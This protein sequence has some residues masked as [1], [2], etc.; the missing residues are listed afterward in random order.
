MSVSARPSEAA[1]P[2]PRRRWWR[3]VLG[4]V[5]LL[6]LLPV[7]AVGGALLWANSEGGRA[8]LARL[9]AG[10]VPGLAIEG[11]EGPLPGRLAFE[12][13]AMSDDQ[14]IWLEIEG[15]RLDWDPLALLR[16]V[17]H[18][19]ALTA[20]RIVLHRLPPGEEPPPP[21]EPGPLIPRLPDLPV[22]LQLDRLEVVRLEL[23]EPVLGAPAVLR[24]EGRAG[25][26]AGGLTAAL[27]A[28]AEGG[29]TAL[30]L[31]AALRPETGRLSAR[32]TL[33]GEA[34]GPVARLI[35]LPDRPTSLDLT[36][37]GPAEA[38]ALTLQASAGPGLGAEL[39]GTLRAPD[40][41]RIGAEIAGTVDASGLL[42]DPVAPFAGPLNLRL[43]AG[44]M[45]DGAVDLRALRIAGR[46]GTIEASGRLDSAAA[47]S[48]LRLRAAL[49]ASTTFAALLPGDTAG[50]EAVRLEAQVTG[51][52]NA[53]RVTAELTAEGFRSG[54]APLAAL[55]G[56]TPRVTLRAAAPDRIELLTVTGQSLQAELRGRVG[57][58]LDVSYAANVAAVE[59]AAPGLS[60][61]LRLAGTATGPATNPNLTL[62]AQSNRLQVAERVLEALSLTARIASPAT[63]PALEARATGRFQNLPLS[64]DLR[65]GPEADGWLRLQAAEASFGPARLSASGR[66]QPEQKLVDGSARL[67]VPQ[68]APFSAV[69]GQPLAGSVRLEATAT[70][71]EGQQH[72]AARLDVPNLRAAGV[73]ARGF[74]ASAQGTLAALDLALAGRV[75]EVDAELRGRLTE[76]EGGIRRLD[77]AT[78]RAAGFGETV[79]LAAPARLALHPDGGVEIGALAITL[80][81][82]GTLR[83]EG[84]WGPERAD[85]RAQLTPL[86]I[87]AF[88]A[89]VPEIGPSGTV[90]A[91]ARITG[92]TAAPEVTATLRGTALRAR[93]PWA[94]G[95]PAGE[96]RLDLRRNGEGAVEANGEARLGTAMR[97]NATARLPRGPG[98]ELPV[99]ASLDGNLE[100]APLA[101][102]M[103]AAGADRV[104]GRLAL[105]LRMS[106]TQGAPVLG[107]EARLS[108]GSYRN[109]LMGV[110][111]TDLAGTVR[112]DGPLLRVDIAGRTPGD[113]RLNL[114]GTIEPMTTNIPVDLALTATQAQPV[115][116]D[117]LRT[118]LD[119]ELR[120][121][122]LLGTGATVAG[123]V[124]IRRAEIRV[125]EKLPTTVRSLGPVTERGAPPG[126]A[127]RRAPPRR[128]PAQGGGSVPI[129]LA[130]Q[131]QA[132]GN[133]FVRGRGLDAELGGTL[134]IGGRVDAPEINGELQL[135]RG[136]LAVV[137]RRL[138][139]DR[140]RLDF[141]GGLMPDLDFRATSQSGPVT[142]RV[143]VT[144][145]PNAPVLTFSS[146]PELPQDEVVARL[147]FDRPLRDLSPF[148]L[149]QIAQAVAGATGLAGGG[150]SGLLDRVRQTLGLDRLAVGSG[151]ET[152]NRNTTEEE[153]N[154]ATLEA[155]RYVAEG[156]YVGVRQG[157]EP[158]SSRVG[159]RVDLTPRMRLEAET[160][161]REAG[162]RV[163]VSWE[164]QW[165]R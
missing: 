4:V 71:R 109:A 114:A 145:P 62:E 22:A 165:G 119:A 58:T 75:Q 51:E 69:A 112:A 160:G 65:G 146:S 94:S 99:E 6:L 90:S 78:L 137:G 47:T 3:W 91:E 10:Q 41:Q 101:A 105:G 131:V 9:A 2:R 142:V 161:D 102:P 26:D 128:D 53:P 123:P 63:T 56:A 116:S 111:I 132:P 43:D 76:V 17:A 39:S 103:L 42:Q 97:L 120:L 52:L 154:R 72:I 79:R 13:L 12:R 64:L 125:P 150:T 129:T 82:G 38:A 122:G 163:G 136:E 11:L 29:T 84:R 139:F 164:W 107:G 21:Q 23:A 138:S 115:A 46:A 36:L 96:L 15:A 117:L 151:G 8:T 40:T 140:G 7:V 19:E 59:G 126:R 54:V 81:R 1:A 27:D 87:A 127:P 100:I 34:G 143:E 162:E 24:A 60:G 48:D 31:D 156:V 5:L 25:L 45:P 32:L 33:R 106:G 18:V 85:L 159:V 113:G 74:T 147:L 70:P 20:R 133:V 144:G 124:R 57:E 80:G 141:S 121:S 155:G 108:N 152:A 28:A 118:V 83:A 153:R 89:M 49:P 148:E 66:F 149:A 67:E 86:D 16:R 104:T 50:W 61:A 135:R 68:L 73:E 77:L 130:V 93:A 30:G 88:A 158:G 92:R 55:L 37:D 98:A 110:A 44:T 157:T 134:A 35:G 95:L 14:G